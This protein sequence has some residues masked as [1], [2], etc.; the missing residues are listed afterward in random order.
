MCIIARHLCA[1]IVDHV[2]HA[3]ILYLERVCVELACWSCQINKLIV[4]TY[5]NIK[6]EVH[7]PHIVN[8]S[9]EVQNPRRNSYTPCV[10]SH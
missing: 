3:I 2:A 4:T 9:T 7:K 1:W 5:Q 10:V 8:E 6:C